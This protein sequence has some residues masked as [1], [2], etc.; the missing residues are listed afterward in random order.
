MI[1][2]TFINLSQKPHQSTIFV[3]SL[4]ILQFLSII[5]CYT[6]FFYKKEIQ[7]LILSQL[8][9]CLLT[10]KTSKTN[11]LNS[12]EFLSTSNQFLSTSHQRSLINHLYFL[13]HS[14]SFFSRT[15]FLLSN[16]F[17]VI[18]ISNS[19][20]LAIPVYSQLSLDLSHFCLFMSCHNTPINIQ[21]I[22][23]HLCLFQSCNILLLWNLSNQ[24]QIYF[25]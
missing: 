2:K 24:T 13:T 8:S 14:T 20:I 19:Y 18:S 21:N 22:S 5:Y 25:I 17:F 16:F 12:K 11:L 7:S 10:W 1:K 23:Y 9:L 3:D 4:N 6:F 15:L